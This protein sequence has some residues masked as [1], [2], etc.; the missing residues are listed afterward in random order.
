MKV[1]SDE[2]RRLHGM[3]ALAITVYALVHIAN[4]LAGLGGVD[5]H[6]S[7]MRA[8]RLIYRQPVVEGLLLVSVAFQIYSGITLVIHGWKKRQGLMPWLQALSGAYLALFLLN[9]VGAVLLGRFVLHLDTNFYYAAAGFH[10]PPFSFF[11]APYYFLGVFALFTHL[12]CAAYWQFDSNS[13][14][15]RILAMVLPASVGF[16]IALLIVLLLAG[17]FY[18]IQIPPKYEAIYLRL[19]GSVL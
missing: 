12:G 9:H 6:I 19:I 16:V 1:K 7:F 11:F 18:P 2:L 5:S 8:A 14:P 10:V 17:V 4:H 13:R 3:S 15:A